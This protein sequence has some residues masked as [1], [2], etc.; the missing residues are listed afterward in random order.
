MISLEEVLVR[1]HCRAPKC[2]TN[3]AA[4]VTDPVNKAA[5][6]L[7]GFRVACV[8]TNSINCHIDMVA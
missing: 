2:A 5:G 6:L 8:I 1:F 4:F 7:S 3:F